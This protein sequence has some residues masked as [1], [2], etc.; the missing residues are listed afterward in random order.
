MSDWRG[1]GNALPLKVLKESFDEIRRSDKRRGMPDIAVSHPS[2]SYLNL[3]VNCYCKH[4]HH[5]RHHTHQLYED[6]K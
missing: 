6:V 2:E 5:D 4:C 3:L 1:P